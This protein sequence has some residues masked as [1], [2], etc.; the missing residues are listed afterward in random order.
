MDRPILELT[1]ERL[2]IQVPPLS[3]A[4]RVL[5][6]CVKNRLHLGPWE[7]PR[8]TEYY[9]LLFWQNQVAAARDEFEGGA[10]MRTVFM[11]RDP[12]SPDGGR[13]GPILGII[14]VSQ[15]VRG[16]FQ[17]AI[18]G[19]SLDGEIQGHGLMTEALG[20]VIDYG[21][22]GLE[23]HRL[24]ANYRPENVRSGAVLER[25]G[26]TKEGYAKEYLFIDG[27]WRDHVLTSI[28]R[29]DRDAVLAAQKEEGMAQAPAASK[30]E[31]TGHAVECE[32]Q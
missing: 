25:L 14:N 22:E 15:I 1:T 6:Y 11:A 19:Y 9:S 31:A 28:R 3:A 18:V 27:A 17:A 20:A 2:I 24:M 23:L 10:S 4:R 21:F 26:F 16:A 8:P 7:P 29:S 5:E 12:D 32:G 13:S 30:V